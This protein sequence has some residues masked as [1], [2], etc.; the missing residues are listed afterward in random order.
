MFDSLGTTQFSFWVRSDPFGWPLFLTLH[1]LAT[2]LAAGFIF[3]IALRLLGFFELIPARALK[4]MLPVVWAALVLEAASGFVLW[5]ARP[6]Q[7]AA[8]FA[9]LLKL[10]LVLAGVGL[11]FLIRSRIGDRDAVKPQLRTLAIVA[12]VVWC[13]VIITS[14]LTGYLG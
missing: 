8:D 9:F 3:I 7:Y 6:A 10:L 12:L 13:G 2:A 1:V 11:L 5:M 4:R 14:R